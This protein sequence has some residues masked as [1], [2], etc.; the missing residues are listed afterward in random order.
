MSGKF[1]R[2]ATISVSIFLFGAVGLVAFSESPRSVTTA[3]EIFR[4]TYDV[5]EYL[6]H[7]IPSSIAASLFM[8]SAIRYR[9]QTDDTERAHWERL[10][11]EMRWRGFS[12]LEADAILRSVHSAIDPT[13]ERRRITL[14]SRYSGRCCTVGYVGA[15][16]FRAQRVC[17]NGKAAWFFRLYFSDRVTYGC[18]D[19]TSLM[20]GM[21]GGGPGGV[22]VSSDPPYTVIAR[23][24]PGWL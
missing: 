14:C 19:G 1:L 24:L 7:R 16:P 9:L 10:R 6:E 8:D 12:E 5:A 21:G 11:R 23:R 17:I 3:E 4:P 2:R 13:I 18:P 22:V 20:R 15:I